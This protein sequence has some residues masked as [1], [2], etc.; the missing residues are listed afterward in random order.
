MK[1][2]RVTLENF[3]IYTRKVFE[4]DAAPLVLIYGPNESGKTTALN[5]LRQALFG[6]K[7]RTPYL[8]GRSMSA[9]VA[10]VLANGKRLEFS[11]R[12]SKQDEVIGTIDGRS[13]S[14]EAL[15]SALCNLD[16]ASYEQLFGFS[17]D[18]LREGEAALKNARLSEALAGGGLGGMHA[19]QQLR[20]ELQGSLTDLYKSRGTTSK[21][22]VKLTDI[23]KSNEALRNTQV[24]PTAVDDLQRELADVKLQSDEVRTHYG[25]VTQARLATERLRDALPKF[26][27]RS[28]LER[29]LAAIDLPH[30]LDMTFVHQWSDQAEQQKKLLARL[31]DERSKLEQDRLQLSQLSGSQ[32]ISASEG[33]VEQ[34]GHQAAEISTARTRMSDLQSQI[35]ESQTVCQRLLETLELSAVD[36][37]LRAF[38]LSPPKKAELE[39]LSREHTTLSAEL[40]AVSARQEAAADALAEIDESTAP[41]HQPPDNWLDLKSMVERLQGLEQELQAKSQSLAKV[42]D[43]RE[44]HDV[45]VNLQTIASSTL[46]LDKGWQLPSSRQ[47]QQHQ[48][49]LDELQREFTA[50]KR[51]VAK[52]AKE[53]ALSLKQLESLDHRTAD[54]LLTATELNRNE[55]DAIL[56]AWLD[57]LSQPL[58]SACISI[59]DQLQR[60]QALQRLAAA[61]DQ[62]QT[63]IFE[64]A[65]AMAHFNQRQLQLQTLQHDSATAQQQLTE[66]S[67]REETLAQCWRSLWSALPCE[68]ANTERMLVW[69]QDFARWSELTDLRDRIRRDAHVARGVVRNLRMQ[70]QDFWPFVLRDDVACEVLVS[71]VRQWEEWQHDTQRDRERLRMAKANVNKLTEKQAALRQRREALEATYALWLSKVPIALAWPLEQVG[72]LMDALERLRREDDALRRATEQVTHLQQQLADYEARTRQLATTLGQNIATGALEGHAERWLSELQAMRHQRTRRIELNAAIEHRSRTVSE[73][74]TQQQLLENQLAALCSGVGS[75]DAAAMTSWVERVQRAD[76][77]R[78]QIA[79]LTASI[80]PHSGNE[81]LDTFVAR[82]QTADEGQLE[83]ELLELQRESQQLD[84]ARK[85]ADQKI[86]ALTQR[87]EQ[88]ANNQAAQ[89]NQQALQDQRGELAELAEQWVVQRLAQELLNRSIERF[90]A[91]HEPALLLH[92]RAYL[93]QLTG[94]RYTT[95]EHDSATSGSFVIRNARDEAYTPDQLSTGTREQLYLAI[96]M[97]FI[98]HHSQHHEPLPVI[99]DDCF[100]NFDDNRTRLALEAIAG[101]DTAVQTILLSCHW[102]VVQSL[103]AFAPHTAVIHL[104]KELQTTAGQL[105]ADPSLSPAGKGS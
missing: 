93:S 3:G 14:V 33:E 25:N 79:E 32:E 94:G 21:I 88:L 102:R 65:D 45:Q 44:F 87:I 10:G 39:N 38:S 37:R 27:Q 81:P 98:T 52:L 60:L 76:S 7:S 74:A 58:L 86:G 66:L 82:L 49:A 101:W 67:A 83:L 78:T 48:Q 16:I 24:L 64:A 9:E 71:Y 13:A 104:E 47:V 105:V 35:S 29:Q 5:G 80:D 17:L 23:Q 56:R 22:N 31:E 26:R 69:L 1:L 90:A 75:G 18:E 30:G 59:D 95:V 63:Q 97:A 8:T 73:L 96:R 72:K 85:E 6:F 2:D 84:E 51:Q 12:K 57:E 19:L 20:A 28:A 11:R 77:L 62:L 103:A 50:G 4:F 15:Q 55:R 46:V 70:L 36:E 92:T 41:S 40:I 43:D 91:A 54:E 61:A 89:R 99:M 34:L 100:V 53:L 68:P 42:I